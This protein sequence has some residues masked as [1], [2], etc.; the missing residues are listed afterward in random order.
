MDVDG[1]AHVPLAEHVFRKIIPEI[2]L[3][4]CV[5]LVGTTKTAFTKVDPTQ[6]SVEVL[7]ANFVLM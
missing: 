7:V 1:V 2:H 5:T 4:I 6:P 3:E